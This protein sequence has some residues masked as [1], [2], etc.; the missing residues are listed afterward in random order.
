MI[1]K[2]HNLRRTIIVVAAL[3]LLLY[4]CAYC[5]CSRV[6]AEF[7]GERW[8]FFQPPAGLH[9]T[10]VQHRYRFPGL[11]LW[12]GWKCWERVPS[13]FFR[14]CIVVDEYLTGKRYLL[15]HKGTICFN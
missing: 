11:T 12:E 1:A 8:A 5:L 15:T 4:V 9:N 3:G 2:P 13:T 14:P 6:L 7:P 10:H